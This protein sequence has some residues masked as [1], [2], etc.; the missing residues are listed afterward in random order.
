MVRYFEEDLKPSIKAEI[1]WDDSQ[2]IDYK[3]LVAKAVRVEAKAGLRP[4]SYM[5]ETDLSYLQGNWPAHT[6]AHK[7]QTQG[8]IKDHCGNDSKASKGSA[9]TPTSAF[10]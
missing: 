2:L 1:D 9:S 7:V 5:R 8:A 10:T 3:E 6:T 4:C